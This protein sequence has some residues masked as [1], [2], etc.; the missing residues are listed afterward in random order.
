MSLYIHFPRSTQ[1]VVNPGAPIHAARRFAERL[2]L[3][4][5]Q[6]NGRSSHGIAMTRSKC[7][8]SRQPMSKSN[9]APPAIV[10][11]VLCTSVTL[12]GVV[13]FRIIAVAARPA[14]ETSRRDSEATT[15]VSRGISTIANLKGPPQDTPDLEFPPHLERDCFEAGVDPR[16]VHQLRP[17]VVVL[18]RPICGRRR[19]R[20]RLPRLHE[21]RLEP[22]GWVYG[23]TTA[24]RAW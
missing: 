12:M 2:V 10:L 18:E 17:L 1:I 14:T 13:N 4:L 22:G 24:P 9:L 5:R 7:S 19:L 15:I 23:L 3:R 21:C 8:A 20:R 16:E 11:P 6:L